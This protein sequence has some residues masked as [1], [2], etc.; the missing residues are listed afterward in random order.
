MNKTEAYQLVGLF[1]NWKPTP[2]L[3]GGR[4]F[5]KMLDGE[6]YPQAFLTKEKAMVAAKENAIALKGNAMEIIR[7]G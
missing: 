5:V 6:W 2:E 3:I 4:W 7:N 1:V